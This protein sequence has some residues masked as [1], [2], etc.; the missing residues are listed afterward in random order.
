MTYSEHELE[1]RSLKTSDLLTVASSVSNKHQFGRHRINSSVCAV[2][3]L[4][5]SAMSQTENKNTSENI[6]RSSIEE[7]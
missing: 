7:E 6:W 2:P 5:A 4:R 1:L 3:N